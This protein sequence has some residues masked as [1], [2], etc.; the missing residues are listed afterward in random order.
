MAVVYISTAI[1]L[2]YLTLKSPSMKITMR[3]CEDF[4]TLLKLS[5][6]PE[7]YCIS[8]WLEATNADDHLTGMWDYSTYSNTSQTMLSDCEKIYI[9]LCPHLQELQMENVLN[10]LGCFKRYKGLQNSTRT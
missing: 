7:E 2:S 5:S 4:T 8:L 3:T 10:H 1:M 9:F 6:N